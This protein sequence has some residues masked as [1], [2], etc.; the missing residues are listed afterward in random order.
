[1]LVAV[2]SKLSKSSRFFARTW[3]AC[4]VLAV[5]GLSGCV[6]NNV[7]DGSPLLQVRW[8]TAGNACSALGAASMRVQISQA[9]AVVQTLQV[10]CGQGRVSAYLPAGTYQVTVFALD[11]NGNVI[12]SSDAT[13]VQLVVGG[14]TITPELPIAA[15]SGQGGAIAAS[16]T[17][18][19]QA[20]A[21]G[22][23]SAGL[24]KIVVSVLDHAQAKVLG[25]ATATC[26]A[27][28]LTVSNVAP[29]AGVYLQV[30]GYGPNDPDGK[31]SYG[32]SPLTGE[33]TIAAGTTAAVSTPID[34]QKL[35]A[36]R[37]PAGKGNVAV[38]WT[39]MGEP[40]ATACAK[41]GIDKVNVRILNDKRGEIASLSA[42]CSDGAATV[43][44]VAAGNGF[45]QLD[46]SGPAAPASWGNINLAG[47]FALKDGQVVSPPKAIDIGQRT[48]ISL[49]WSL[50]SATCGGSGVQTVFVE[51][52]DAA[53][54]VVIPMSDPW[55]GKPCDLSSASSYDARV[56]DFGFAQPQCAIPPGA[57]GLVVCNIS[58][59][60]IGLHATG[61]DSKG[62]PVVGGSMQ[63]SP[64]TPG[65]HV[66]L[67]VVLQLAPCSANNVCS[68]P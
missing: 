35:G 30:D 41:R 1:M 58:A 25:S 66:A 8:A 48:V 15:G 19:G 63:V 53:D 52:R 32:N 55:A 24:T 46:A 68:K 27:G 4:A 49:D 23:A 43:A 10:P 6:V 2:L 28:Q 47:P 11:A 9:G 26:A 61:V 42:K 29:A 50:Q 54:K 38:S 56:L 37:A 40:A 22:C 62:Q 44:N 34:L 36:A 3:L 13:A 51:V 7:S 60:T 39:V 21:A 17:V 12:G 67:P 16:W 31:P 20:P 33:F 45:V 65:N 57:K 18:L 5:A 59:A 14:T 64:V